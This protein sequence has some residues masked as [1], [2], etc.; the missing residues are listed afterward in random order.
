[1]IKCSLLLY[2]DLCSRCIWKEK[3]NKQKKKSVSKNCTTH[4]QE[5]FL[6]RDNGAE[7]LLFF[8]GLFS[9]RM[10]KN[11]LQLIHPEFNPGIAEPARLCMSVM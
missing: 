10:N 2:S 8:L 3:T 9:L 5:S 1:M 4:Q 7:N 11:I 6:F